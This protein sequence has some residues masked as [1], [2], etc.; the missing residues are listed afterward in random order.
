MS[1]L[2]NKLASQPQIAGTL[3]PSVS[4]DAAK[5]GRHPA[6]AMS[7]NDVA[8][9]LG[10]GRTTVYKLIGEAR[11]QTRKL[12]RRTLVLSESVFRLLGEA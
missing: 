11:L 12:G 9:T 8:A 2:K 3:D 7:V 10:I 1:E 4:P 5:P 6:L